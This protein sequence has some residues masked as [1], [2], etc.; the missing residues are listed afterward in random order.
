[1]GEGAFLKEIINRKLKMVT[2]KYNE[3]LIMYENYSLL[4]LSTIYGVE[5]LEDNTQTC[6]LNIFQIYYEFYSKIANQYNE[7]LKKKVL[8][9]AKL[10]IS[11]NIAQGDFLTQKSPNGKPIVFSEWKWINPGKTKIKVI[12]TEF[13]LYDIANNI[14]KENGEIVTDLKKDNE[15]IDIFELLETEEEV[16]VDI[17]EYRYTAVDIADA[18]REEIE[19]YVR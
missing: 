3:S 5:L 7:K 2:E 12:R 8:D 1:A 15:Q 14:E 19:I 17:S 9:S 4:A 6:S 11:A 10:I 16:Q 13:T 18:Y